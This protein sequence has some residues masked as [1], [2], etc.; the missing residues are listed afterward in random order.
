MTECRTR[1]SRT[2]RSA[3][4]NI[5]A[6]QLEMRSGSAALLPQTS[7]RNRI[8]RCERPSNSWTSARRTEFIECKA[9]E[10][11]L[12]YLDQTNIDNLY[13]DSRPAR[14]YGVRRTQNLH[15][16]R[17]ATIGTLVPEVDASRSGRRLHRPRTRQGMLRMQSHRRRCVK[18]GLHELQIRQRRAQF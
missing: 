15:R 10:I 9:V 12:I 7:G 4:H 17:C 6:G 1:G 3:A 16:D 5:G 11:T 13:R 8:E 18:L 14:R 2:L